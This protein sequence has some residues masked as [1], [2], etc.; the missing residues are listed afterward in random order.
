MTAKKISIS[1]P[2]H[3]YEQL[4]A[5]PLES[6]SGHIVALLEA[7][8]QCLDWLAERERVFGELPADPE[9]EAYWSARLRM[10]AEEVL[11]ENIAQDAQAAQGVEPGAAGGGRGRAA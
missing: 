7:E 5:R 1:L 10:T 9:A 8:Q 4:K 2:E 3:L 6:V 11:A